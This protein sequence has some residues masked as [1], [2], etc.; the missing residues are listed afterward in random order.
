MY[1][2]YNKRKKSESLIEYIH[3]DYMYETIKHFS[4]HHFQRLKR[5]ENIHV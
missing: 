5:N 1:Q 4:K 3:I 2:V